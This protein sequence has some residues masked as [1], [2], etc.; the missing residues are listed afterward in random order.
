MRVLL[1][2]LCVVVLSSGCYSLNDTQRKG[3]NV[4]VT[5]AEPQT[6]MMAM[7]LSMMTISKHKKGVNIVL[8]GPAGRLAEKGVKKVKVLKP[9]GSSVS[10]SVVLKKLIKLGASVKVCPLYLPNAGKNS[11]VFIDGVT[12]AN[13]KQ[14]AADLLNPEYGILSY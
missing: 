14:V 7:A 10:P 8:C 11:S 3:L 9:D 5:S 12:V 1:V 13:P 6:Q 4:I 2:L